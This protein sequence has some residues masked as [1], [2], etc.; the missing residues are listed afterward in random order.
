MKAVI[1][2]ED[3]SFAAKARS[4]LQH[5]ADRPEV[6]IQWTITPWPLNALH[7]ATMSEEALHDSVDA[8][9]IIIPGECAKTF[10]SQFRNWLERWAIIRH[11]EDAAVGVIGEEA[12]ESI[13]NH[14]NIA[15]KVLVE[16]HG[17]HLI[18]NQT[19]FGKPEARLPVTFSI[20]NELPLQF[21]GGPYDKRPDSPRAFGI[22]E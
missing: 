9:L 14:I 22:N 20:E 4:I 15:L 19:F 5:V 12:S 1:F 18:T 6:T 11:V 2:C 8:Y 17:L 21:P 7:H 13:E 10:P 3:C 16:K